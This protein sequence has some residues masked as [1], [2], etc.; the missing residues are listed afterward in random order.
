MLALAAAARA[1]LIKA[2]HV[3]HQECDHTKSLILERLPN[4]VAFSLRRL[5]AASA[6]LAPP[7][8]GS[9]VFGDRA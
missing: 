3:D 9:H 2:F 5:M 4:T 6:A 8:A 7:A 1:A